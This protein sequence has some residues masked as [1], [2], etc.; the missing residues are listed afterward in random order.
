MTANL[1]M[2][3][4]TAAIAMNVSERM[5]YMAKELLDCRPDLASMVESGE[6]TTLAALKVAKPEK[7]DKPKRPRCCLHCGREQVVA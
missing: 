5:V 3:T 6:M 7:Y 1:Q 2:T 4:K